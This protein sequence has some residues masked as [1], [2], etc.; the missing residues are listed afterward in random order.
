MTESIVFIGSGPVA[1]RSLELLS[2]KFTVE[3]IL[4]KPKPA[5][6]KGDF[7]V[8]ETAELLG[9]RVE[10]AVNRADL[11]ALFITKPFK[12]KVAVLVDFGIIV[13][14]DVID[15]FPFGIINS[16]FSLLPEWRGADPIAFAILSGQSITGVSLMLLTAGMDEGPILAYGEQPIAAEMTTPQLTDALIT[17]SDSLLKSVL[18]K[19]LSA[20]VKPL[21]QEEASKL[22]GKAYE[23]TYSRKLSKDDGVINWEKP[24][25][26]IERE[27]RAYIDWPKSR[28]VLGS[29]EVIITK[30]HATPTLPDGAK[31]GDLD[32]V[33][34]VWELGVVT[35]AGTLWIE[36]LKPVGKHDMD[37]KN[38][39][40][41]Y[42]N[43]LLG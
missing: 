31:P 25:A 32:L 34:Q 9:I 15:Y 7:P 30:A 40:I 4:T 39:L 23:P 41:G 16:H 5:H 1:A 33:D 21:G 35:G 42:R 27:I 12:S 6:H 37:I 28:T 38:F 11:S 24:A 43:F 18:P 10:T 8:V 20:E 22:A 14:Q 2:Q 26:E 3:A 13:G 29:K 19:Y 36:R 17:L